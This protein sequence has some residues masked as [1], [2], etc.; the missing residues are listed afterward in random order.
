MDTKRLARFS[1]LAF[2][3][4]VTGDRYRATAERV[5]ELAGSSVT[6]SSMT[7]PTSP[8]PRSTP[9]RKLTVTAFVTRALAFF[10]GLGITAHRL[11]TDNAWTYIHHRSL[12]ELLTDHAIRHR[13][14][15]PRTPKR[16]GE[17][18]RCQQTLAREWAYGQRYLTSNARAAV[19]PIRLNHYN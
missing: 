18:E 19:L 16:N 14:I 6:R 10:A 5:P 1:L 4:R 3:H 9:T 15:P 8:T 13:R 17:V 12:A 7:P 11:Q 2:G